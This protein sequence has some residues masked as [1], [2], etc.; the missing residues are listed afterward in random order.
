M[1]IALSENGAWIP[2]IEGLLKDTRYVII[3]ELKSLIK[4]K[5]DLSRKDRRQWL[6]QLAPRG[7]LAPELRPLVIENAASASE[8]IRQEIPLSEDF[9]K[10]GI[11]TDFLMGEIGAQDLGK[12]IIEEVTDIAIFVEE[13]FERYD[14]SRNVPSW[15]FGWERM[16][17]ELISGLI[18][19]KSPNNRSEMQKIRSV[20]AVNLR[21]SAISLVKERRRTNPDWLRAGDKRIGDKVM[22]AP[23]FSLP[24][25]DTISCVLTEYIADHML[26]DRRPRESDG[27]DM[28]HLTYAPYS[29][30][31]RTDRY[32]A[33]LISK[34]GV[35]ISGTVVAKLADLPDMIA[36]RLA[37]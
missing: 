27:G 32:F 19:H 1:S 28:M 21:E 23:K 5:T 34:S 20:G 26:T 6:K 25:V 15:L 31:F 30:F 17:G 9:Y 4:S 33:E 29:D 22:G 10:S 24:A 18:A 36:A 2:N 12:A 37:R 14:P 7:R 13:L 3:S 35:D 16:L 8:S 11:L